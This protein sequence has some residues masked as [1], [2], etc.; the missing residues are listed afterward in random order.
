[1]HLCPNLSGQFACARGI[2]VGNCEE[3]H[4]WMLRR[5]PRAQRTNA[6]RTDHSQT[7]VFSFES[8]DILLLSVTR[9]VP[10]SMD[11][12]IYVKRET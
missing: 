11:A 8:D 12:D 10:P 4:G 7:E 1:M 2:T 3:A 9:T 5:E 6:A